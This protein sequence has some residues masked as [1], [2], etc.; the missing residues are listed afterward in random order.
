MRKARMRLVAGI[1]AGVMGG[2]F[3]LATFDAAWMAS[4]GYTGVTA[5]GVFLLGYFDGTD[6]KNHVRA[7]PPSLAAPALVGRMAFSLSALGL[8]CAGCAALG[9]A[10]KDPMGG[11][12][13][14]LALEA[15]SMSS[16]PATPAGPAIRH[17]SA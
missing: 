1:A 3:G 15:G 12:R 13:A 6:F 16:E 4:S 10:A 14:E 5:S 17:C 11:R 2:A 9:G 7:A 8:L